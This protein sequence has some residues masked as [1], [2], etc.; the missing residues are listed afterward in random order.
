MQAT[1]SFLQAQLSCQRRK[2]AAFRGRPVKN[3][4]IHPG[5]GPAQL[6]EL[7]QRITDRPTSLWA[8]KEE[9]QLLH[10]PVFRLN[11]LE[12]IRDAAGGIGVLA[13]NH[14]SHGVERMAL[15]Q[16]LMVDVGRA[17]NMGIL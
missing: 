17:A 9:L 3:L 14:P 4:H 15:H 12:Q 8:K 11:L 16:I 7:L 2:S 5:I 10:V 6:R 13:V 1:S